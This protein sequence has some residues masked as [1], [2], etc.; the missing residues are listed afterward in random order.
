MEL[1]DDNFNDYPLEFPQSSSI[2]KVIGVGGGGCNVVAE[3]YKTGLKD[4][5]LMICNT[6]NQALKSNPVNEKI[7]LGTQGLGAGLN[8]RKGRD[9]ALASKEEIIRSLEGNIEMVFIT[10]C[11]GGGTG[12][13][14]APVIAEIAKSMNKLVV[15]VV[16]IPFRD[17][18]SEFMKRAMGGLNELK[19]HVDSLLI[20]DN[21]KIYDEYGDLPMKMGFKKANDVLVTA[22][23]SISEVVTKGGGINVDMN[24][25]RMIMENSGMAILGIGHAK[26]EDRAEKAVEMAFNSPL[27]NDCDLKTSKG[28]LLCITCSDE[29]V[30]MAELRQ[31]V[32][33]VNSF[34]G[35]PTK[36]KRG[37]I[38][39]PSLDDEVFVTIIATGFDVLNLPNILDDSIIIPDELAEEGSIDKVVWTPTPEPKKKE[40]EPVIPAMPDKPIRRTGSNRPVLVTEDENEIIELEN[41]PAYIRKSK[42]NNGGIQTDI[43][44]FSI[45]NTTEGQAIIPNNRYLHQTQD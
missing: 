38:N 40:I 36:F 34:T 20:I 10:A 5:D 41:V 2:I 8:P 21:Q 32:E 23:K 30:T 19:K 18:G 29:K 6:D 14:A 16:T 22:V 25:V 17:E 26:G 3:I 33:H 9:S 27:L 13:G 37:I 28:A 11:L 1:R 4:V 43:A 44:A 35:S 39:D 42:K 31:A 12:T 45:T 15:G 24:D 7:R